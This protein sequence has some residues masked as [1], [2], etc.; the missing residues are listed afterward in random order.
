[1]RNRIVLVSLFM[2]LFAGTAFCAVS[3]YR[4]VGTTATNLNS[5][6]TVTISGTTAT[7]S[8]AMPNN[9]GVGDA[10][11]YGSTYI[12]FICG[13]TNSTTFTVQ[14]SNGGT[15][16]AASAVSANVYRCYNSLNNCL[17]NSGVNSNIS[18]AVSGQVPLS[19]QNLTSLSAIFMVPCY[20]DGMDGNATD[21]GWTT[22][23][24]YYI[25]IY[26]P[27]ASA[28]VGASQRHNGTWGSGYQIT[29]HLDIGDNYVWVDGLSVYQSGDD[30]TIFVGGQTA[31]GLVQI[32]DCFAWN[33]NTLNGDQ[34]YPF[35]DWNITASA[36]T[37][38]WWNDI[39]I[40]TC[41]ASGAAA[42]YF[43]GGAN[44]TA[45][46]Y[47]C[48]GIC[49]T[50]YAFKQA[51]ILSATLKNCLGQSGY[52]DFHNLSNNNVNY[53]AF[54]DGTATGYGGSGN[55]SNQTF[56]FVNSAANNYL[57]TGTDMGARDHGE[58]LA[59][60]PVIPFSYDICGNTRPQGP[61]WDIGAYEAPVLAPVTAL[62]RSVGPG[63]TANLNTGNTLTISGTN[64]TFSGAMPNNVG[65]GDAI[66]YGSSIAFICG[67]TDS[68]H[69]TVQNSTGGPP[70]LASGQ[71]PV[72]TAVTLRSRTGAI[73]QL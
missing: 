41:S 49:P 38:E 11:V 8:V 34:Q 13:C 17:G 73:T 6:C 23:A 55:L 59:A 61:A 5:A 1:M 10:I 58:S 48:T 54:A 3:L 72:S 22:S 32:S 2:V 44:V 7:F 69:F 66:V 36:F 68:Q 42:F 70:P 46:C 47:N 12:A 18:G 63:N 50:G 60:D 24:S 16:Q 4:S 51:S 56:T 67:R 30:R 53:C 57:I 28:E 39:G 62:Y 33:T 45:Y 27:V 29:G 19:S 14:S 43:N 64:A 9:V 40:S 37:I 25:K 26:T 31:T 20:A 21:L 35:D 15:P 65:V 52:G 71:P